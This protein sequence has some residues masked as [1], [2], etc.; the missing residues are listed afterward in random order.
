ME[1][2][3][4]VWGLI[5]CVARWRNVVGNNAEQI[6]AK[7]LRDSNQIAGTINI[8]VIMGIKDAAMFS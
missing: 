1:P 3:S 7:Y 8:D 4:P 5:T 6:W 2:A